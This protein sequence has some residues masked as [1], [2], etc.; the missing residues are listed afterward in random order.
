MG[1]KMMNRFWQQKYQSD[2]VITAISIFVIFGFFG[3]Y[4]VAKILF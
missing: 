1:Y 3:Y 4:V 2:V